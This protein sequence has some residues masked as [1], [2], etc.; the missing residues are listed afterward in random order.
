VRIVKGRLVPGYIQPDSDDWLGAAEQMLF[1]YREAVGRTRGEIAADL[2]ELLA[3]GPSLLVHQGLAKLLDDRCEYEVATDLKPDQVREAAFRLSA[4]EH[5][6]SAQAGRPFDRNA[7]LLAASAELGHPPESLDQALFA[8]LQDEQR[9]LKFDNC[10]PEQ[11]LHRYN[12]ALAQAILLRAVEIEVHVRGETAARFRA[13]FRQVKFRQLI[14]TVHPESN[15]YRLTLDGPLSLFSSTQKYGLQ[16]ALFLPALL[17]CKAFELRANVR[18]GPERKPQTF[19]LSAND[20]L[21]SHLPDFGVFTPP[22][23]ETFAT[24]F[25]ANVKGWTIDDEPHP[26]PVGGTLWVP[27][28]TLTHAV[29]GKQVYVE[30][31]GFWRKVNLEELHRRLKK[32]LPGQFV[33]AVSGASRA[34]ESTD[35]LSGDGIYHFKRT[36][37]AAEVAKLAER[38]AGV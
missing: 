3:D 37:I 25:R 8:D 38:M 17:H 1:V 30:I 13:L 6:E 20:G 33:L 9:V 31:L 2:A 16:L 22:V 27:D 10:T 18:W 23:L 7:V 11:L 19:T 4:I 29:T 21:R 28:F 15:G 24:N 35:E 12:L 5:A 36:P 14:C 32:A 34:D 26:L